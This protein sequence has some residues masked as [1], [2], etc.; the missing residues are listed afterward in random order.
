M[1]AILDA[2]G[3]ALV[4]SDGP[5]GNIGYPAAPEEIDHFLAML[6][7]QARHIDAGQLDRIRKSF[8]ENAERLRRP[9]A[10]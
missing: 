5:K 2:K 6:K 8:E 1:V 4:T 9:A 7:G 3:K 10:H